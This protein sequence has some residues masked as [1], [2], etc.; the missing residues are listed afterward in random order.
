MGDEHAK[1]NIAVDV[2]IENV[3]MLFVDIVWLSRQSEKR[4]EIYIVCEGAWGLPFRG[5]RREVE[6]SGRRRVLLR[7]LIGLRDAYITSSY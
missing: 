7:R 1:R 4:E 2:S 5:T 3:D 6:G